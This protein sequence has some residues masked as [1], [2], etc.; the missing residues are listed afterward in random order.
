MA[1][2]DC[3]LGEEDWVLADRDSIL[4]VQDSVPDSRDRKVQVFTDQKSRSV[5]RILIP[6]AVC[7]FEQKWNVT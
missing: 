7:V 1:S 2:E 3:R 6:T 4:P 5:Y